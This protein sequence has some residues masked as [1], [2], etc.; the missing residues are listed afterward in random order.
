MEY[1]IFSADWWTWNG[2]TMFVAVCTG[3][4]F[5]VGHEIGDAIKR[6]WNRKPWF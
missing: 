4:A 6:I 3:L 1:A 5:V 2:G